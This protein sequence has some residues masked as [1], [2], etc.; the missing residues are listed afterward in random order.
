MGN[1]APFQLM[2]NIWIQ[3][4]IVSVYTKLSP[5]S[6]ST[7]YALVYMCVGSIAVWGIFIIAFVVDHDWIAGTVIL[8][9]GSCVLTQPKKGV[10]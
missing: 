2:A 6:I 1:V 3:A 9:L 7:M 4:L 10:F 8:I 5:R